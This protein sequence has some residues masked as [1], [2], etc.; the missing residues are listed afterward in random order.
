M[1]LPRDGVPPLTDADIEEFDH[2]K[3]QM[4]DIISA[5]DNFN[6]TKLI[7]R[8]GFG[9]VYKG[10]LSL[11]TGPTMV[12]F[13]RLDPRLGQ[14]NIEFWKEILMLSDC[15]HENLVSLLHFSIE[16]D[17]RVLVY[18]YASHGSLD[19][20]L[21]DSSLTWEQRLHICIG[22]AHSLKYLHDPMKTQQI[23][24]HRDIKSANILLDEQWNAKVSDFGL[25]KIWPANQTRSYLFSHPVGTQGYCDPLYG[26]TGFLSKES[27]VYSFGVVLFEVLC[28]RLCYKHR[29]AQINGI[30]VHDWKRCYHEKKLDDIILKDLKEQIN[31]DSLITFSTIANQ[32]LNGD[33]RERPT[34]DEIVKEL[35]VA[36]EQQNIAYNRNLVEISKLAV[37][38][39]SYRSHDELILLLSKGILVDQGKRW[40]SMNKNKKVHEMISAAECVKGFV[41]QVTAKISRFS[42]IFCVSSFDFK[43]EVRTQFLSTAIPYT[44]NL[45]FMSGIK[46][47][48]IYIPFKYKLEEETDY[49]MSGVVHQRKDGWLMAEL[50]QFTSYQ[51]EHDFKIEFLSDSIAFSQCD[52]EG[53]EFRP[54]E[55]ENLEDKNEVDVKQISTSD[56]DW[57]QKGFLIDNGEDKLE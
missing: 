37:P 43:V 49:L 8:G 27:D 35:E 48:G 52:I 28:G 13:K 9:P 11:L 40:L 21:S 34:M 18:E 6:P 26:E 3:I 51:R 47:Y 53:I 25:S 16:G 57:E 39:L 33:R 10:E 38:P 17:E 30:L 42:K 4:E 22:V 19:H 14:G 55:H 45:I 29:N 5:T 15:K 36:L 20:Y 23:V 2:L 56:A 32:C 7:G 31:P 12:A 1:A 54:M 50:Y 41:F 44:I 46:N 24:L